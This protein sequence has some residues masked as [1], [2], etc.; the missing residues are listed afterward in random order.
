MARCEEGYLCE[1]CGED[2][3]HLRDSAL[4]LRFIIGW[5]DPE[6]LHTQRECHLRC[7]PTLT[8]FIDSPEFEQVTVEGEFSRHALDAKFASQRAQLITRGYERLREIDS[9]RDRPAVIEY[10]LPEVR[11]K[12]Q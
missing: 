12:W 11:K 9:L 8:Q 2:V 4:Y 3:E 6:T 10:L 5:I 1:V 7:M